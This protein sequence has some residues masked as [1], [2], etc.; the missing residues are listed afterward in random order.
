MIEASSQLF[1]E[2]NKKKRKESTSVTEAQLDSSEL[3]VLKAL[4][5]SNIVDVFEELKNIKRVRR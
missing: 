2:L 3:F 5:S 4:W 1:K